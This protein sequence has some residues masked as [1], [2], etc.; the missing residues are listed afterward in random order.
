MSGLV[1]LVDEHGRSSA[2]GVDVDASKLLARL[3]ASRRRAL[4]V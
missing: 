3:A 1:P 4:W 2:I